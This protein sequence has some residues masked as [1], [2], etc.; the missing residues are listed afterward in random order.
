MKNIDL[1]FFFE[2]YGAAVIDFEIDNQHYKFESTYMGKNPLNSLITALWQLSVESENVFVDE[3]GEEMANDVQISNL[4]WQNEPWGFAVKLIKNK[5]ELR[6]IINSFSDTER[7]NNESF[8]F[9][10]LKLVLDVVIDF[11]DFTKKVCSEAIKALRKYGFVGYANTWDTAYKNDDFPITK[12]FY[13]LGSNC[14]D[15]NDMYFSDFEK[16]IRLL[17]I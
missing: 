8:A 11:N 14:H 3:N 2:Y 7:F 6:I 5:N 17:K 10:D 1:H 4:I 16:E 12:L 15:N 13:L 9:E